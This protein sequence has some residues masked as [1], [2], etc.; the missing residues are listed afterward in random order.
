MNYGLARIIKEPLYQAL[1]NTMYI[2]I[3][4]FALTIYSMFV[5]NDKVAHSALAVGMLFSQCIIYIGGYVIVLFMICY[6]CQNI[7]LAVSFS[8]TRKQAVVVAYIIEFLMGIFL[9]IVS[10]AGALT[11]G[12]MG[13]DISLGIWILQPT[14]RGTT[15][16]PSGAAA[17]SCTACGGMAA[18]I[19]ATHS[20]AAFGF[21]DRPIFSGTGCILS[22]DGT[23]HSAPVRV[24]SAA[25]EQ[26][27]E[28]RCSGSPVG[29]GVCRGRLRNPVQLPKLV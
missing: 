10:V 12:L 6:T 17:G 23:G 29:A 21:T 4:A 14:K 24:L 2:I 22:V 20:S 26:A 16:F 25:A 18:G 9:I 8:C 11:A 28:G 13:V 5:V 19:P 3:G 7:S 15:L 27:M 1:R